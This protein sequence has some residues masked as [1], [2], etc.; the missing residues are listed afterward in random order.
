MSIELA[1]AARRDQAA[2]NRSIC[3]G[4]VVVVVL[5]WC[6]ESDTVA[7]LQSVLASDH[8]GVTPLLVDNGSPDGSGE[9][10]H[11]AFPEVAYLQTGENLGFSGGNNRGIAWAL[12]RG[13]DFVLVLNNDAVLA[14]DCISR[15]V[16]AAR[17]TPR[18][19][20]VTPK[21]LAFDAP[22]RIWY[23]GGD[24][25]LVRLAGRHRRAGER[26][27]AAKDPA[28]PEPVSFVTGCCLLLT[29]AALDAVGGFDESYFAY[30]EDLDLS[31]RLERAGFAALYEPRARCLHRVPPP[32]DEPT[33]FQIAQRDRN[34]RRLAAARLS[35]A[36]RL[37]FR[38][39]YY[40][41]RLV[42]LAHYVVRGDR[43][44][45]RAIVD[46]VRSPL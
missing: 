45:A 17:A 22:E 39:W 23:A 26:D 21:I 43:A 8:D 4:R 30:V 14:P 20:A 28:A 7:C 38:L 27:D 40:P 9:R 11:R 41:T 44:R 24:A 16:A 10:L 42:H 2:R 36:R 35:P 6:R 32:A 1:G 19:G 18:V 46:G 5:N 3:A 15:L 31:L 29:P 34:R 13:A 12:E 37:L 33:P 25:S